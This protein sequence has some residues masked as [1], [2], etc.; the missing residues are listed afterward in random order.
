MVLF[1]GLNVKIYNYFLSFYNVVRKH[2]LLKRGTDG[3]K[4]SRAKGNSEKRENNFESVSLTTGG[5]KPKVQLQK[6]GRRGRH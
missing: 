4:R 2:N 5:N 1:F 3:T 6:G